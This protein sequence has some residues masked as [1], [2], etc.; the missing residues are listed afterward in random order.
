MFSRQTSWIRFAFAFLVGFFFLQKGKF[1]FS[2]RK[3]PHLGTCSYLFFFLGGGVVSSCSYPCY[4]GRC[5]FCIFC[6]GPI[7]HIILVFVFFFGL[8]VCFLFFLMITSLG[9]FILAEFSCFY[10]WGGGSCSVGSFGYVFLTLV[11][12]LL[13]FV[14]VCFLFLWLI[15]AVAVFLFTLCC[16][17]LSS[18]CCICGVLLLFFLFWSCLLLS[19][20]F[21]FLLLFIFSSSSYSFSLCNLR[22]SQ[23]WI[24]LFD[25]SKRDF[26]I[27]CAFFVGTFLGDGSYVFQKTL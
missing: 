22:W 11:R 23:F 19:L 4:C 7:L 12:L 13:L 9:F 3:Q 6:S 14:F 2:P 24:P 15:R 17:G 26:C 8:S 27:F 16:F 20:L 25:F 10:L 1:P 5:C 18:C 21:F